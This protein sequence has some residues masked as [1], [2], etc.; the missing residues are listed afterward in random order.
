MV[1]LN[2]LATRASGFGQAP[3]ALHP[4]D[5]A[6]RRNLANRDGDST[7]TKPTPTPAPSID[8]KTLKDVTK[9][10]PLDAATSEGVERIADSGAGP[11]EVGSQ[12]RGYFRKLESVP[13]PLQ[14]EVTS[15]ARRYA[16]AKW[17]GG[18]NEMRRRV[19]IGAALV[20][21]ER[22]DDDLAKALFLGPRGG[23]WADAAHTIPYDD[24]SNRLPTLTSSNSP[25]RLDV[26]RDL[27]GTHLSFLPGKRNDGFTARHRR[28]L[29]QDLNR[30]R[31]SGV[32][33]VLDLTEAWE[34]KNVGG[35][36]GD[37]HAAVRAHG[38]NLWHEPIRDRSVPS[39]HRAI[40]IV[41]RAQQI[42]AEGGTVLV[43]CMGGLGRTGVIAGMMLAA[44]KP[45]ISGDEIIRRLRE[46]RGP[47]APDTHAQAQRIKVFAGMQK[48]SREADDEL[49]PGQMMML[50]RFAELVA[51]YGS[52]DAI[53]EG[54]R[55]ARRLEKGGPF[56]GPK[57]GKWA[58]PQHKVHWQ[59]PATAGAK[60]ANALALHG[61][62]WATVHSKPDGGFSV[63]LPN[64]KLAGGE[65][66][67]GQAIGHATIAA[68]V[69][70]EPN[71]HKGSDNT[72]LNFPP[73]AA[74]VPVPAP[75]PTPVPAPAPPSP[76]DPAPGSGDFDPHAVA[77]AISEK[78][79][80]SIDQIK[81][82][83]TSHADTTNS[84]VLKHRAAVEGAILDHGMARENAI[85]DVMG[86]KGKWGVH[87]KGSHNAFVA[88]I[89][90]GD[91]ARSVKEY[92]QT[93][94]YDVQ[95]LTG[96]NAVHGHVQGQANCTYT[97]LVTMGHVKGDFVTGDF[98][99]ELGH[100]V[101]FAMQ[102]GTPGGGG[103][104]GA[105]TPGGSLTP[106][107][108]AVAERFVDVKQRMKANPATGPVDNDFC[109]K[110]WGIIS[111]RGKDNWEEN[112]A[113]HY[114]G[115]HRE[116]LRERYKKDGGG[117]LATYRERHPE[118]AA[119]WDARYTAALLGEHAKKG[120]F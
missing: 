72:Y 25:L 100:A 89:S 113:E 102:Q 38:L 77:N 19:G 13:K 11:Y 64:K 7:P 84:V 52:V 5:E 83:L 63:K 34:P 2:F 37:Y 48:A 60:F 15:R 10:L 117:Q 46:S 14:A 98:R 103:H 94:T 82:A 12:L 85:L 24:E 47:R 70:G 90:K 17:K 115:Y 101:R 29:S 88:S 41:K 39:M 118:W 55:K 30:I 112:A 1:D 104:L 21:S 44:E 45:G 18:I 107:A 51:Q 35:I 62:S 106:M 3:R 31:S 65:K 108:K 67:V 80:L 79:G 74:P 33:H 26:L 59:E 22:A 28:S 58:D 114:R 6:A 119:I 110:S 97:R 86:Q 49:S 73:Q 116:V 68:G 23:K 92:E 81:S 8:V 56:I 32:T 43:H 96:V 9:G 99:H 111:T 16:A 27:P 109:E 66:K 57:G 87:D 120:G 20:R 75:V 42:R 61:V 69:A 54:L 40:A 50:L 4:D 95:V 93:P 78:T 105:G 76:S 91:K 53:P 71:V 36:A